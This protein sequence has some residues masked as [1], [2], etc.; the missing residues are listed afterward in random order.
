VGSRT[1]TRDLS[2][3]R[4]VRVPHG[5]YAG[6]GRRVHLGYRRNGR[7]VYLACGLAGYIDQSWLRATDDP[8]S[9]GACLRSSRKRNVG[10][11]A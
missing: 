8:V 3:V 5:F 9:C 6:G 7:V 2:D 10:G 1:T 4:E 11:T